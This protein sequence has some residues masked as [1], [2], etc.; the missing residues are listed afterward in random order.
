MFDNYCAD[1]KEA[2]NF[3]FFIGSILIVF[4]LY[5]INRY[6]SATSFLIICFG[7]LFVLMGFLCP[8]MMLQL[9]KGWIAIGRIM[10]KFMLP[11]IMGILFMFIF[12]PVAIILKIIGRDPLKL[13]FQKSDVTYWIIKDKMNSENMKEQ[14]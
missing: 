12:T 2:R 3:G 1:R 10:H 11:V 7:L 6:E 4:A 13:K 9:R 14:F 8:R 5:K